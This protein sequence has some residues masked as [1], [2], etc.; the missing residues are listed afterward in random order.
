MNHPKSRLQTVADWVLWHFVLDFSLE[1]LSALAAL[2]WGLA[3]SFCRPLLTLPG[4]H[5]LVWMVSWQ[6][7]SPDFVWGVLLTLLGAR[8][9]ALSLCTWGQL[10]RRADA[11]LITGSV[12][13]FFTFALLL[14]QPG[15]T[16][17]PVY[18]LLSWAGFVAS[19][20]LALR[21]R[22]RTALP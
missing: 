6:P 2:G 17:V 1:K 15:T 21:Q 3:V 19:Y 12:F 11:A 16:G 18:G 13:A 9:F 7:V 8:Q 4:W 10:Q 22:S 14:G 5:Y 20:H